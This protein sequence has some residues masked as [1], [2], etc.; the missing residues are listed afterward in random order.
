MQAK[1]RWLMEED[2]T[3]NVDTVTQNDKWK[4]M[5]QKKSEEILRCSPEKANEE[6]K[7]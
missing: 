5:K 7:P 4:M 1:H 2:R 3:K 6:I